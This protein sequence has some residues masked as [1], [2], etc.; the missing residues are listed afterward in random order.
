M[1]KKKKGFKK[2][3]FASKLHMLLLVLAVTLTINLVTFSVII[4]KH[5][6]Q[7]PLMIYETSASFLTIYDNK[8]EQP[9]MEEVKEEEKPIVIKKAPVNDKEDTEKKYSDASTTQAKESSIYDALALYETTGNSVGIDVSKWNG[10]INWKT[11]ADSGVEFAM[12]RCGYRG[13]GSGEMLMDPYFEQNISGALKNGIKVGIYFYSAAVNEA[14]ARE[15]ARF[16]VEVI[17]KYRITYPVVYDFENFYEGRC[18]YLGKNVITNNALAFLNYVKSQGYTPMMYASK[19]AYYNN[20]ETSRFSG[21]KN[22]LAHYTNPGV[23]SDY[24]GKYQMWQYTSKGSVPGINGYVDMN[25]AY[26]KYST[27]APAKTPEVP[28]EEEKEETP[29]TKEPETEITFETVQEQVITLNEIDY[30]K[31][32]KGEKTGTIAKDTT[33]KRIGISSDKIWSK[34]IYND[35]EVY[36]KSENVK[37][38]S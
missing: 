26:F 1:Q 3:L 24:T 8:V 11:V 36:V 33:L 9:V 31:D 5:K 35:Q 28:K 32:Y 25:T 13:Y 21:M 29:E 18:A 15:E 23:N 10:N 20:W 2:I 14:E 4:Y 38:A 22:W 6:H 37:L 16:T 7:K 19:N 34:V 30:Y 12:I 17:K 27:E